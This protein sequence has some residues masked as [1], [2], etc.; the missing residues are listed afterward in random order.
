[1]SCIVVQWTA[2]SSTDQEY[3]SHRRN[4]FSDQAACTKNAHQNLQPQFHHY[5]AELF[6]CGICLT[7]LKPSSVSMKT[8]YR[9]G[10]LR[11][12]KCLR[13]NFAK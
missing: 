7:N 12:F 5:L 4:A 2:A 9:N 8:N 1:M 13:H 6:I 3:V 10:V 11:V